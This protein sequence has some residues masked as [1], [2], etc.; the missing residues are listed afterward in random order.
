MRREE[1]K[2]WRSGFSPD[3]AWQICGCGEGETTRTMRRRASTAVSL[4]GWGQMV[5]RSGG[6]CG[7]PHVAGS[8][9][10]PPSIGSLKGQPSI[11]SPNRAASR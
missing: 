7:S 11:G 10:G 4:R 5:V 6:T 8:P 3:E 2:P 9:K 1:A